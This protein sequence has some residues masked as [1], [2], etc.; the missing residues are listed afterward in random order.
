M[1]GLRIKLSALTAS[2][3]EPGSQLYHRCLPLPPFTTLVGLAG[4][5]IGM[6]FAE[7]ITFF[8]EKN[9]YIGVKGSSQGKGRDLWNYAKISSGTEV[10]K[11]I[12]TREFLCNIELEVFY[13]CDDS[14]CINWLQEAF[15]DPAYTLTLG[16]SDELAL[17]KGSRVYRNINSDWVTELSN[18]WLPG[19]VSGNYAFDWDKIQ[20]SDLTLT[21]AAPQV[22]RLPVDFDFKGNIRKGARYEMFSFIPEYIRLKQKI[23]V[24]VFGKQAVPMFT[25][26]K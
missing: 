1:Q 18:C 23:E 24:Y 26:T 3:R 11:D 17:Y 20:K 25:L 12:I 16:N 5:A 8:K 10:K 13:A 4:A 7:A 22:I 9:I 15:A 21:L 14:K 19:D 2:F 6:T